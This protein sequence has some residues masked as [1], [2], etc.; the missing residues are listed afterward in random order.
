[1]PFYKI[2]RYVSREGRQLGCYRDPPSC[3]D[4]YLIIVFYDLLIL[5]DIVCIYEPHNVRRRR[6]WATVH[7]IPGRAD[8]GHRVKI[9]LR[10]FDGA[11]RLEEKMTSA[12]ARG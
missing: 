1:M 8:I 10:L 3:E 5:N 12:I 6:L 11:A 4:E 9:D 2:R 7:R